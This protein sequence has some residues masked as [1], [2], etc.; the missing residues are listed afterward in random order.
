MSS[1]ARLTTFMLA[2]FPLTALI[3]LRARTLALFA[4]M[5]RASVLLVR[6]RL[7]LDGDIEVLPRLADGPDQDLVAVWPLAL[8]LLLLIVLG[9]G[10]LSDFIVEERRVGGDKGGFAGWVCAFDFGALN[11]ADAIVVVVDGRLEDFFHYQPHPLPIR[12][13]IPHVRENV[14]K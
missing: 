7:G 9:E 2:G 13:P 14:R 8:E 12:T 11:A 10:L 3:G 6:V 4:T 1:L 5:V